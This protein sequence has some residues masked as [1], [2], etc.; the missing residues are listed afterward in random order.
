MHGNAPLPYDAVLFD[1]DGVLTSTAATRTWK[2]VFDELPLM[3]PF[4]IEDD[5]LAH[6]DGK[7]RYDGVRDFLASRGVTV[8]EH[9][10]RAIGDRKQAL[11]RALASEGVKA[12]DDALGQAPARRGRCCCRGVVEHQRRRR[13]AE[14]R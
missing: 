1:L 2:A 6:V 12:Y 13:A 11:E 14:R 5:Y 8:S 9:E 7:P 3:R 10:I 4:D